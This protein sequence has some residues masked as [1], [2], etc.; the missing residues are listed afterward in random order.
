MGPQSYIERVLEKIKQNQTITPEVIV[1][2]P[3]YNEGEA[4]VTL[5]WEM[6]TV[7]GSHQYRVLVVDDGSS[8]RSMEL[9]EMSG[10]EKIEI[11]RHA[12]NRGLGEAIRTGLTEALAVSTYDAD[13]IVVM[14]SDC[15]HTPHLMDRMVNMIKEGNDVVIASRYRYGSRVVGLS[16]FRT[17]L[18]HASSWVFRTFLPIANVKDYTC[19]YRAYRA[20]LLRKAF[21]TYQQDFIS[22]SGFACMVDILLKLARMGAII[23]EVPLI[24][25]YDRKLSTSK[26]KVLK[27]IG[28]SLALV[29][30]NLLGRSARQGA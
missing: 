6:Q 10:L 20:G 4:L 23:T 27:T 17:F 5:L 2:L 12:Q 29:G 18:S 13:I 26:M 7:L 24:L 19:G 9:V 15:T 22:E 25:R 30:R 14:D 8:D 16:L 3:A 1:V 28:S 11:I 21:E